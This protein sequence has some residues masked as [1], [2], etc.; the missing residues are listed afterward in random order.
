[1]GASSWRR[2]QQSQAGC[3]E[4]VELRSISQYLGAEANHCK[5]RRFS[6]PHYKQKGRLDEYL[7]PRHRKALQWLPTSL[8]ADRQ[9]ES[10]RYALQSKY[11]ESL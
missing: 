6:E 1:M 4:F 9:L 2:F 8:L 3:P 7:Y 10:A 5:K 11:P